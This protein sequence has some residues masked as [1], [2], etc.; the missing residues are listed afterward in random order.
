MIRKLKIWLLIGLTILVVAGLIAGFAWIFR[1]KP[2]IIEM[3]Q[4]VAVEAM[5]IVKWMYVLEGSIH[6]VPGTTVEVFRDVMADTSDYRATSYDKSSIEKVFGHQALTHAGLL[7]SKQADFLVLDLPVPAAPTPRT[8]P[9][10]VPTAK[11]VYLC[12]SD[13]E[14]VVDNYLRYISVVQWQEG[15]ITVTYDFISGRYEAI[16]RIIDGKWKITSVRMIKFYGNG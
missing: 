2:V 1:P 12:S 3:N 9:T 11:P 4:P 15:H 5:S 13:P 6:C 10:L 16:L 7:T 14:N 8:G